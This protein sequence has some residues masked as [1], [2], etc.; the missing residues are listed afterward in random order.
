MTNERGEGSSTN[1]RKV[2]NAAKSFSRMDTPS[3]MSSPSRKTR[4]STLQERSIPAVPAARHMSLQEPENRSDVADVFE[5]QEDEEPVKAGT[6]TPGPDIPL[7]STFDELPIEIQS[8]TKR[9]LESLS[10]RI[11]PAPLSAD[12]LSDLFQ[13]FYQRAASHIDTHIASLSSRIGRERSPAPSNGPLSSLQGRPR[14]GSGAKRNGGSPSNS[15]G[16]MLTASEVA[17]RRKARR[18]LELERLALEEAVER[19]VCEKTYKRIYKHRTTD[20]DA[21]DGKLRSRTAALALVGIGL[22]ELHVDTTS[23]D[24]VEQTTEDKQDEIHR[25]L[26]EA[27]EALQRMEDERYPL[28]KLQH[29]TVAHKSIVDTLSQLF[30]SSSSADEILPTLIYTLITSSPEGLNVV[31]NLSFIQRFRASS[32]IDGEAAYCLV[33][34]EAAVSFLETVDLSSLRAEELPQ[35]PP[36]T[37]SRPSTP[38]IEKSAMLPGNAGSTNAADTSVSK[39]SANATYTSTGLNEATKA[40]PQPRTPGMETRPAL[41]QRRI[42]ALVQ[43]QADRIEAGRENLLSA[44]DK[45]YESINGTLENSFQFVFGRFGQHTSSG[46]PL[47]KTLE[48]ARKLVSSPRLG[49]E[50]EN[51]DQSGRSSPAFDD[52]LDRTVKGDKK[53]LQ[54]IGGRGETRDRSVDSTRSGGSGKRLVNEQV[55]K[56]KMR[57]ESPAQAANL[58]TSTVN[59]INTINPLNRFSVPGFGRFRT[60]SGVVVPGQPSPG[61]EKTS[62]LGD[63]V[64]SPSTERE[65]ERRAP[66]LEK[67]SSGDATSDDLNARKT[68]AELKKLKPPRKRFLDVQ[69]AGEL[70]ISEVE[71]LLMDYRRLSKAIGEAI[72]S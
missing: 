26:A 71:E 6:D 44:A 31:S 61:T 42:S 56:D 15:G 68:I 57:P 19:V 64:E 13:D 8:L 4:A 12:G 50:E 23:K 2:S 72:A 65:R 9:F 66:R 41:H 49:E 55:S 16:E 53:V 25:S 39:I 30:P 52:P 1:A 38:V 24:G 3:D 63:I 46:S 60:A 33:N 58:F 36:K 70:R 62:R 40:L 7:T 48:D 59:T 67:T 18:L 27:R 34:L 14:A 51:L 21:R 69:S 32:K 29:L 17:E 5:Y 43:A 54:M 28:G 11:H 20:D 45:V 22:K 37:S 47:P 10:A 35:G